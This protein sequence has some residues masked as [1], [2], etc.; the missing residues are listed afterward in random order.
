MLWVDAPHANVNL[1]LSPA[2]AGRVWCCTLPEVVL[3]GAIQN[4]EGQGDALARKAAFEDAMLSSH[5]L[6]EDSSEA[7]LPS[8][9]FQLKHS[10]P[11]M[12][13]ETAGVISVS[14]ESGIQSLKRRKAIR[15]L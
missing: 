13:I 14:V 11:A 4:V 10:L 2:L 3:S 1:T 9:R 8:A 6:S 7:D 12:L 5:R 15:S